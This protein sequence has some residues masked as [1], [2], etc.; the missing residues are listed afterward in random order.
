[1]KHLGMK[2]KLPKSMW[3]YYK[4]NYNKANKTRGTVKAAKRKKDSLLEIAN[5]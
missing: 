5:V 1:M 4:I 3:T 2:H